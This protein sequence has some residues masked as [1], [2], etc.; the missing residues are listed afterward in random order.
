M[1]GVVI[2][3]LIN[4]RRWEVVLGTCVV[5]IAKVGA[6]TDRSL[7]LSTGIGLETHDV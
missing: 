4:E 7:F 2:D 1:A 3:N 6:D 5:D